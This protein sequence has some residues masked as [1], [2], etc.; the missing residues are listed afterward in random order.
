MP[1]KDDSTAFLLLPVVLD[2]SV[3]QAACFVRDNRGAADEVLMLDDAAGLEL[4]GH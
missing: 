3:F 4:A 1:I 2:D